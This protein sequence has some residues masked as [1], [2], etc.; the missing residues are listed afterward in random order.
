[1][2]GE[3]VLNIGEK[4]RVARK[5]NHLSLRELAARADVSPSL[6]SQ[7]ENGRA[8]PSVMTLYNIAGALSLPITF[9]FPGSETD[10]NQEKRVFHS[11]KTASEARSDENLG[12]A[13][14]KEQVKKIPV[15]SSDTRQAIELRGGVR[16]ERLTIAEEENV[17]FLEIL[18]RAGASSGTAMSHHSGRE[19]GIVLSGEL[20]LELGFEQYL[21]KA[22]DS[23]LFDSGTPHR[24]SNEGSEDVRAIWVMMN[25]KV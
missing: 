12:F 24:L 6:L 5:E 19:F 18:Y 20:K 16:W 11:D 7:I 17:Q 1:M 14:T 8:N 10:I 23:I 2:S 3:D 13:A 25:R 15:L 21:L 22:G 9:F 4:L